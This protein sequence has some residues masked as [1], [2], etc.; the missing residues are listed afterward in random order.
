MNIV[1]FFLTSFFSLLC[2]DNPRIVDGPDSQIIA[3]REDVTFSCTAS[4]SPIPTISWKHNNRTV[5]ASSKYVIG[6]PEID[7]DSHTISSTLTISSLE[8]L[9]TGEVVC[10]ASVPPNSDVGD[11]QLTPDNGTAQLSVLGK[12]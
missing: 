7:E 4:G 2:S 3:E 5:S 12:Q 10:T 1:F 6:E 11:I 8:A 9:D